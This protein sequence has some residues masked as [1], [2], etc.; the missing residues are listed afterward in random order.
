MDTPMKNWIQAEAYCAGTGGHLASISDAITNSFISKYMKNFTYG[1]PYWIGGIANSYAN[2]ARW[3]WIDKDGFTYTNWAGG[4]PYN[5]SVGNCI[6]QDPSSSQWYSSDCG[7]NQMF[8][9]EYTNSSQSCPM[10]N[11]VHL[12]AFG[13]K[14]ISFTFGPNLLIGFNYSVAL[15]TCE[16]YGTTLVSIHSLNENNLYMA[17]GDVFSNIAGVGA[18]YYWIGASYSSINGYYVWLDS[19]PM[20]FKNFGQNLD[21]NE[22]IFLSNMWYSTACSVWLDSTPMDF[23]NFGQNLDS[24]ECIFLSN[25]WY[26]TACSTLE[27]ICI[28]EYLF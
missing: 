9:C 15:A 4:E 3:E 6:M 23:K 25:M 18:P 27:I 14:C 11:A 12:T 1:N 21:S 2:K 19:T 22:C 28:C 8:V 17:Y 7:Y 16:N 5:N 26:S 10:P 24:N 13:G 20:D